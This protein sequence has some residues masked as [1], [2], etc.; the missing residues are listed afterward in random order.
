MPDLPEGF[1][2]LPGW[3]DEAGAAALF[4]RLLDET[5]WEDPVLRIAGRSVPMPRRV[6]FHGPY[7]YAYSG[8]LHRARALPPE[9]DAVRR[10]I[11]DTAGHPF[12]TVLI[13]LYRSGA[14]S[15]SWHSDDDYAHGGH[16]AVASLS[17]GATRRF[18]VAPRRGPAATFAIDLTSGGLLVMEGRSQEDY[19]HALPKTTA[20]VGPRI[21]LTFRH[22]AASNVPADQS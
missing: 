17:L 10:R 13:N 4:R 6:A 1:R 3:L 15:V 7:D 22:M 11:A 14:D 9:V 21:N 20:P 2:W 19:R 12:N 8:H 16:P 5:P 18:R